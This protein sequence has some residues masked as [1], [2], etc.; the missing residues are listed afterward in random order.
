MD[1]GVSAVGG[2][3]G[4]SSVSQ[5]V[6]SLAHCFHHYK[7]KEEYKE[8]EGWGTGDEKEKMGEASRG[9]FHSFKTKRDSSR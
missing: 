8:E 4:F 1:T 9:M 7:A 3:G 2:R 5:P 6:E